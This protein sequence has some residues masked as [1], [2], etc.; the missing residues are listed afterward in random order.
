M[1]GPVQAGVMFSASWPS[2]MAEGESG[3]KG[4]GQLWLFLVGT[5]AVPSTPALVAIGTKYA[6]AALWIVML[7]QPSVNAKCST[8]F[9]NLL[10]M[11]RAIVVDVIQL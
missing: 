11:G 2:G 1:I 9:S 3:N 10:T 4:V 6:Q 8:L 5:N 7:L